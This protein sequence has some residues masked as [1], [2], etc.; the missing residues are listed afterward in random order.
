[1]QCRQRQE[2]EIDR[3]GAR[4]S[5][6][7]ACKGGGFEAVPCCEEVV[8]K[9]GFGEGFVVD[10]DTLSDKSQVGRGV[11]SDFAEWVFGEDGGD[12]GGGGA[13]AFGT[14]YVDGVETIE[15]GG[16]EV[17][18]VLVGGERKVGTSELV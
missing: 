14:G 2:A 3:L 16:L 8:R 13:F 1:M 7:A 18:R 10:L 15:V 4:L 9:E 12:E 5:G 6:F 17:R 11:K